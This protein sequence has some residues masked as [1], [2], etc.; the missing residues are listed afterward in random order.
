M[1]TGIETPLPRTSPSLKRMKL[2]SI[3]YHAAFQAAG[4]CNSPCPICAGEG[5]HG[6]CELS[7]GH[8]GEHKCN[9]AHS[10]TSKP[11]EAPGPH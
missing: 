7:A 9:H 11:G 5:A 2:D 10:W 8:A 3:A 4:Q 6:A 1:A